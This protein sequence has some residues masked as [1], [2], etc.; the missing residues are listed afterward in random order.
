M[1]LQFNCVSCGHDIDVA[2][3][4]LA[5]PPA[6]KLDGTY[7]TLVPKLHLCQRCYMDILEFAIAD[8]RTH[9][10]ERNRLITTKHVWGAST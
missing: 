3:A 10:E 8:I 1:G 9:I 7:E 6:M 4:I 2:G 5:G